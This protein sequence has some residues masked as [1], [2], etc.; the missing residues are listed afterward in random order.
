M[1]RATLLRSIAQLP[2]RENTDLRK[3][4][5]KVADG[6][7]LPPRLMFEGAG[8]DELIAFVDRVGEGNGE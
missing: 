4:F 2:G 6:G 3:C 5:A 1:T 8:L 7:V